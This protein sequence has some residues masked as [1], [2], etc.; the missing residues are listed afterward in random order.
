[1]GFWLRAFRDGAA[2]TTP[3]PDSFVDWSFGS[4]PTPVS[5]V[6]GYPCSRPRG[7]Q[8]LGPVGEN[9]LTQGPAAPHNT[10]PFV[11]GGL[12]PRQLRRKATAPKTLGAQEALWGASP[13]DEVIGTVCSLIG[14]RA[15]ESLHQRA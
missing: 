14:L 15:W 13:W 12:L 2:M 8:G 4:L 6:R 3:P 1:M 10:P 9:T 7:G 5:T 11:H